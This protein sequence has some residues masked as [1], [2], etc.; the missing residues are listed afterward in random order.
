MTSSD[1]CHAGILEHLAT[2]AG[3]K[4][5]VDILARR[6]F[7]YLLEAYWDADFYGQNSTKVEDIGPREEETKDNF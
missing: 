5:N 3:R 4:E 2:G 7:Q 6:A 1:L